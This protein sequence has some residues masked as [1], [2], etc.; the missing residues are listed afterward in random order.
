MRLVDGDNLSTVLENRGPLPPA[1]AVDIVSQ[2]AQ[3][4]DAAHG[5]GL[6]HRDVTPKNIVITGEAGREFAYLID[7]GISRQVKRPRD[8]TITANGQ[9]IGTIEYIA[10]ERFDGV[11][12]DRR[13]DVYS[14]ACVLFEALTNEKAFPGGNREPDRR[15][16]PPPRPS[17]VQPNLPEDLNGVVGRGLATEP[18]G[19]YDTAGQLAVAACQALTSA[20]RPTEAPPDDKDE[21]T[22]HRSM[23]S[24]PKTKVQSAP[25]RPPPR[26][27]RRGNRV[28]AG[29]RQRRGRRHH[30]RGHRWLGVPRRRRRPWYPG[31]RLASGHCTQHRRGRRLRRQHRLRH[32]LGH[33]PRH[34]HSRFHRQGERRSDGRGDQP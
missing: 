13:I 9:L 22:P 30:R 6:V 4:L 11:S 5:A 28:E 29:G 27:S 18:E 19:R 1:R 17:T 15:N 24:R 23:L 3:A 34:P 10:P 25:V 31:W 32:G 16:Q 20:S 8:Q 7:F 33:R 12:D 21:S 14:L 2:I 26:A